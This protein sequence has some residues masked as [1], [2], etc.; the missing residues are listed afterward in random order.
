VGLAASVLFAPLAFGAVH[1]WAY[2]TL[3]A[4]LWATAIVWCLRA[5]LPGGTPSALPAAP[6]R[7]PLSAC[8]AATLAVWL[9]LTLLPL[10]PAVIEALSP[11]AYDLLRAALPG[12]PVTAGYATVSGSAAGAAG[13][14]GLFPLSW[15]PLALA[16]FFARAALLRLLAY[17]IAFFVVAYYPWR[18]GTQTMRRL[19]H[20]LL[21]VALLEATYA[22]FQDVTASSLI[23]WY[24]KPGSAP[25]GTYI[26][27]D[28]FAG[29][30]AM[31]APVSGGLALG[32]WAEL[33]ARLPGVHRRTGSHWTRVLTEAVNSPVA[34]R[35]AFYTTVTVWLIVACYRSLSRGGFLAPLAASCLLAPLL[36]RRGAASQPSGWLSAWLSPAVGVL[37]VGLLV[38]SADLPDLAARLTGAQIATGMEGRLLAARGAVAMVADFPFTGVGLGNFA[39]TFP[40]YRDFGGLRFDHAHNDFLEFAAEAGLPAL[41]L[42]LFLI[43]QLYRRAAAAL[44]A[45]PQSA[46]LLWG[47]LV[48]V[49]SLLLHSFVD[50]NL[51]IP[52]NALVFA[53]LL[54]L[55]VRLSA[56]SPAAGLEAA[57][58]AHGSWR[59]D[60]PS[61]IRGGPRRVGPAPAWPRARGVAASVL[62][63]VAL[64]TIL[65]TRWR[66]AQAEAAYRRRYSDLS[67]PS[68]VADA[69]PRVPPGAQV[70]FLEPLTAAAP[71]HP[72]IEYVCGLALERAALERLTARQSAAAL[73]DRAARHYVRAARALPQWA[74]PHLQL[75]LL[76][77]AGARGLTASDAEACLARAAQLDPH[78]R[79]I[80]ATVAKVV[81]NN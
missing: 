22:L 67:L 70:Q 51:H 54:G 79:T 80:G 25:S 46:Y 71:G 61:A 69:S 31:V 15:R 64:L 55:V 68:L 73:I 4:I 21:I 20:L 5:W 37:I 45:G 60:A 58:S 40:V 65:V 53:V 6:A 75:G 1:Y 56:P 57:D 23:Y 10:P 41:A 19:A 36:L 76:G 59:D 29:L 28:H 50:F 12:W 52:A 38:V 3:E 42:V 18:G 49:T 74:E 47:A 48:G 33:S 35:L 43:A 30:L 27:R 81:K 66:P 8:A 11:A 34:L 17:A 24:R 77:L 16:P 14:Q 63:A 62:A 39:F 72:F 7:F 26:N 9:S 2:T 13:A 44:R 78:N 32:C